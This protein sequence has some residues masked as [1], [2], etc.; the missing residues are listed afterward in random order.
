L[1]EKPEGKR[2]LG[3]ARCRYEIMGLKEIGWEVVDGIHVTGRK[4]GRK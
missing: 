3:K 4:E 1:V 2:Q